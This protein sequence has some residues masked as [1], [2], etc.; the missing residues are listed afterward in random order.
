MAELY[1]SLLAADQRNLI[2][3]ATQLEPHCAGF[4]ID[5]MDNKFVPNKGISLEATHEIDRAT[6]K[7]LWVHL[8]V[9]N[10]HDYLAQLQI[11]PDSIVTFHIE[12]HK[13]TRRLISEI[14]E[15]KWLPGIA[16]N[17]KTGIDEI[18]PFL[19]SIHQA[20]IMSVQPGFAGQLFEASVVTKLDPLIGFR[21]T[22]KLDFKIAMDGGINERNIR[23]LCEKGVDQLAL[24]STLFNAAIGAEKAL[25][26]YTQVVKASSY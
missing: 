25:E 12:S 16:V 23:M 17:P 4:H 7:P 18:F 9:E 19:D 22:K 14:I 6:I 20:L 11:K 10:P 2:K 26:F 5:I 1:P 24:G 13:D 3:M 8:M 15:K 21:A